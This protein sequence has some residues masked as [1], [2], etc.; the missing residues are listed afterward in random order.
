MKYLVILVVLT[1]VCTGLWLGAQRDRAPDALSKTAEVLGTAVDT[2]SVTAR[3]ALG[4]AKEAA[5]A[6]IVHGFDHDRMVAYIN[7]SDLSAFNKTSTKAA[8][9]GARNEPDQLR[10]VLDRLRD[11]LGVPAP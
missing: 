4:D 7:G 3:A 6:L 2:A 10:V 11:R 9:D 1:A 8:L 5:E